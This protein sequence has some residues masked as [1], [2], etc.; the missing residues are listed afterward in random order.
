MTNSKNTTVTAKILQETETDTD[1]FD[2]A[3]KAP[4]NYNAPEHFVALGG[5]ISVYG[6]QRRELSRG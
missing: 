3:R 4:K 2:L 1:N 6:R 5:K